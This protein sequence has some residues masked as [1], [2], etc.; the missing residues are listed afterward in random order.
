MYR[1]PSAR[2]DFTLADE[3]EIEINTEQKM[4]SAHMKVHSERHG[5]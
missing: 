3:E 1:T 4:A 2:D 5:Y